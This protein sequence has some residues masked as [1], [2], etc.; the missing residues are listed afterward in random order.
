MKAVRTANSRW[1]RNWRVC[2]TGKERFALK[3]P[4][5]YSVSVLNFMGTR[6]SAQER[7][8]KIF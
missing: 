3:V 2:A 5:S 4:D 1:T 8:A 6:A 7:R